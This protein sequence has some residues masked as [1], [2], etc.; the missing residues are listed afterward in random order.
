MFR[1]GAIEFTVPLINLYW[2]SASGISERDAKE[3]WPY[4]LLE[5]PISVFRLASTIYREHALEKIDTVLADL[6]IFGVRGWTLRPYSPR[7]FGY[8]GLRQEPFKDDENLLFSEPLSFQR[9]QILDEPD[10]CGF[11]LVKQVYQAF[12]H[13]EKE[14][15]PKEFDQDTGKLVFPNA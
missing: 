15:I 8:Q 6:A 4:C 2:K 14:K 12:G 11:R 9:D 3:I 10:R 1:D 7:S 5:Y 13:W